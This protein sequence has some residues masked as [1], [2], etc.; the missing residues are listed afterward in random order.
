MSCSDE[1]VELMV[2]HDGEPP[3]PWRNE[4][5]IAETTHRD[6]VVLKALPD[7]WTYDYKTADET[8]IMAKNIKRWMQFP[9]SQFVAPKQDAINA[10]YEINFMDSRESK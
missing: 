8:Y 7:E 6:R 9:D 2:W 10:E 4:W 5:F 1:V 3:K